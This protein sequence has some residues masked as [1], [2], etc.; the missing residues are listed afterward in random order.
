VRKDDRFL[1]KD[2][3]FLR[4]CKTTLACTHVVGLESVGV[5][6]EADSRPTTCV[7]ARVVLQP[8]DDRTCVHARVV[9]QPPRV[10][11]EQR[12]VAGTEICHPFSRAF[13]PDSWP[14]A[15]ALVV[16][17]PPRLL[18]EQRSVA[19]GAFIKGL[20]SGGGLQADDVRTRR[21]VAEC[22]GFTSLSSAGL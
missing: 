3:R 18:Y 2:D 13:L 21:S 6:G 22:R 17:R 10:L 9:L 1:R 8:T 5:A 19:G 16:L 14:C 11:Y 7:H 20:Y 4:G 15:H 12:S